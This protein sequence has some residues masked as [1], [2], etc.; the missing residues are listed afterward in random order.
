MLCLLIVH[1]KTN[2]CRSSQC[3]NEIKAVEVL[4]FANED[5]DFKVVVVTSD[6]VVVGCKVLVS[7]INVLVV[8]AKPVV[9]GINVVVDGFEVVFV[10]VFVVGSKYV[11]VSSFVVV[12]LGGCTVVGFTAV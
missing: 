5:V 4:R 12:S 6:V 1:L 9:V 2:G 10:G 7:G 8:G 11:V 3:P